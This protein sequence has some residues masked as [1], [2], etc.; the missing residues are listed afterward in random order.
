MEL[1]N[2]KTKEEIR[3]FADTYY[4]E[5]RLEERVIPIVC[6]EIN[7]YY[8]VVDIISESVRKQF[9]YPSLVVGKEKEFL[10]ALKN[11]RVKPIKFSKVWIENVGHISV[12]FNREK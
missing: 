1:I 8:D 4:C 7:D 12:H 9:G 10:D 6:E 11:I 5:L 2:P 3:K